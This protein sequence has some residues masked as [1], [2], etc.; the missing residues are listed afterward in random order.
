VT[1]VGIFSGMN[2]LESLRDKLDFTDSAA[3]QFH[4]ERGMIPIG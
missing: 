3:A 2:E 4:I 1:N